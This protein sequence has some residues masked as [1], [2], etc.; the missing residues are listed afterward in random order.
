[1]DKKEFGARIL[2]ARKKNGLTQ[3]Q[4]AEQLNVTHT[5]V[6]HWE[7]GRCYPDVEILPQIARILQIDVYQFFLD[8]KSISKKSEDERFYYAL[9]FVGEICKRKLRRKKYIILLLS[10]ICMML[11]ISLFFSLSYSDNEFS[12]VDA[13]VLE[14]TLFLCVLYNGDMNAYNPE[15][16]LDEAE[17][18]ISNNLFEIQNYDTLYIY[19]YSEY[20]DREKNQLVGELY[21]DLD[22][23]MEN[24]DL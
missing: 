20:Q 1:M 17:R 4:L 12:I 21:Y 23:Y 22:F 18:I 13:K 3:L 16:Y 19:I 15:N 14:K 5:A 8:E 2:N 6:S 9:Q 10:L 7:N 24:K 11:F